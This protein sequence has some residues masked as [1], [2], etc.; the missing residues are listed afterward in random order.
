MM[1]ELEVSLLPDAFPDPGRGST[2]VGVD[3]GLSPT[4]ADG[5]APGDHA[6]QHP[7]AH[8]WAPGVTLAG[9]D[10][11]LGDAG[12]EHVGGDGVP[13]SPCALALPEGLDDGALQ[14]FGQLCS[15][16]FGG[17]PTGDAA[18]HPIHGTLGGQSDL[19]DVVVE[20]NGLVQPQEHEVIV[21]LAG[22]VGRVDVEL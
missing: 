1:V 3:A 21:I 14:I 4:A 8:Q 5:H 15:R 2:D 20:L 10:A 9:I 11:P 17:A 13:I 18:P 7:V 16:G 22:V 12:A 6:L 19:L